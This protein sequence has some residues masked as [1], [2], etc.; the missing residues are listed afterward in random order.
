MG[1]TSA[2]RHS[3][4]ATDPGRSRL[5]LA[6]AVS[7]G[8]LLS[9]LCAWAV[10]ST[11]HA[12]EALLV[13]GISMAM[14]MGLTPR[15]ATARSRLAT[16][17]L[18][19][20]PAAAGA[21]A[22]TLLSAWRPL[23][24]ALLV[25][26]A[27]VGTW[28]R[29]F[30][31][32]ATALGFAAFFGCFFPLLL[33]L[34]L[35]DLGPYLLVVVGAVGSLALMRTLL[36]LARPGHQLD[37]L[38]RELR[39]AEAAA[40][41][42]A[43]HPDARRPRAL[44]MR[45]ARVDNVGQAITA[46]QQQADTSRYVDADENGFA[47]LVLEARIAVE[48]ACAEFVRPMPSASAPAAHTAPGP[49][50]AAPPAAADDPE[51]IAAVSALQVVL[52]NGS[53]PAQ[54]DAAARRA[55][56]ILARIAPNSP[57]R[58]LVGRLARA[59]LAHRDLR[60][61]VRGAPAA[62]AGDAQA[63]ASAP[64]PDPQQTTAT[65]A[66]APTHW[67]DW[68]DWPITT[69]LAVQIMI[70]TALATVVGEFVSSTRWYWAVLTAFVVFVGA[71]TRGAILTRAYNR[72][73][74]TAIGLVVGIALV[75]LVHEHMPLLVALAIVSA[76]GM[77]YFGPVL[78]LYN[79]FFTTTLLVSLYG[80][81]GDLSGQVMELR[82]GETI[83]G[84]VIGVACAYLI[85]SS[86]S[87]PARLAKVAA[88]F[89]ALDGVLAAGRT[90]A[91]GARA[92]CGGA[93]RDRPAAGRAGRRR[94]LHDRDVGG[95]HRQAPGGAR[96]RRALALR[97]HA[98]RG[99]VRAGRDRG[100]HRTTLGTAEG[101]CRGRPRRR[102]RAPAR[103]RRHRPHLVRDRPRDRS[104]RRHVHPRPVAAHP[105][106]RA[107]AAGRGLRLALAPGLGAAAPRPREPRRLSIRPPDRGA[108]TG[109]ER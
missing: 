83:A 56:A 18:M 37:L 63:P 66:A 100:L 71:S 106:R 88:F 92:G 55:D 27:G 17:A 76:F 65:D 98:C 36:L 64:R 79:A 107:V 15:D 10:V 81:L 13:I 9:A 20:I 52:D 42:A 41:A 59:A 104:R 109:Q 4:S 57:H 31:P 60:R 84:A 78:Y 99:R 75:L 105:R 85:F 80:M 69:R 19:L 48:Q 26:V 54:V 50:R 6:A 96:P 53:S 8:M 39:N 108:P 97:R 47:A 62:H 87:R 101:G 35:A 34:T 29:R 40:L 67:W 82:I 68:R 77:M 22:T 93:R 12:N 90:R 86:N 16:T 103:A 102:A 38:L 44:R 32:R 46:W 28:A 51:V 14:Q 43:Q 21:V 11:L 70:A 33:Q 24:I 2:I 3:L 72:I 73:L 94:R 25:G 49:G 45:L 74:G 1:L 89:G 7:T 91:D 61:V 23:E 95:A 30:G 58:A 5:R